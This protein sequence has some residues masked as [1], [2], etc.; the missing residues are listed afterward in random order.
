MLN[1]VTSFPPVD[2]PPEAEALR[3]EVR[4]FLA[5]ERAQGSFQPRVDCWLAVSREF[6]QKLAA[7]GWIG[8]TWPKEYGGHGRTSLER[9]VVTEELLAAGAPIALHWIGDRQSGP[10]LLN[11]GSERAKREIIPRLVRGESF[12]AIGMS[13]PDTGSDLASVRTRAVKVD[14]GWSVTGSKLWT[15]NVRD[16]DYMIALVRTAPRN[17][18]KRH[19]GLSQLVIDTASKGVSI[20][21][22]ADLSG[23]QHFNEMVFTDAFVPD[24][25]VV[26]KPGDGWKQVTSELAF[27]RSGPERFLSTYPLVVEWIRAVGP[28][29]DARTA[30]AIGRVAASLATLRRMSASIAGVLQ[31]GESPNLQAAVVKDIGNTLE[32]EIPELVRQYLPT[33]P[34]LDPADAYAA[35]LAQA[36]LHSPGFTL[37]GGTKEILRGIIARGLGL[38]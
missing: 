23:R 5:K 28:K 36:I 14:G 11:Y 1:E 35:A 30:Q 38:R 3:R 22:I 18:E 2:L 4:E 24:D 13:E 17:D 19:E 12:F 27:E 21:P 10:L 37:R 15:S 6:S 32:Q 16:C 33:E 9:Y 7:Q 26:G 20:R 25:M 29:P 34:T 8:M 31:R